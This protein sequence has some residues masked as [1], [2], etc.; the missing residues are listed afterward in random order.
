MI[1][2]SIR[3]Y[4]IFSTQSDLV[5]KFGEGLECLLNSRD[6][7]PLMDEAYLVLDLLK[8]NHIL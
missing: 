6:L 8:T 5:K 4:L 7:D 1:G 2:Q 3:G